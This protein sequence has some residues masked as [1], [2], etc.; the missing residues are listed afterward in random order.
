MKCGGKGTLFKMQHRR[1]DGRKLEKLLWSLC[2]GLN[3]S[4]HL[5]LPKL[6]SLLTFCNEHYLKPNMSKYQRFN[7]ASKMLLGS[8]QLVL[9]FL[10]WEKGNR[11]R[12]FS[13]EQKVKYG[14]SLS[15]VGRTMRGG[16]C[17]EHH[18]VRHELW[19]IKCPHFLVEFC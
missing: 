16:V 15:C 19:D 5:R 18:D 13:T 6:I 1:Y 10:K 2:T 8:T 11:R 7:C 3:C 14:N 12:Q 9:F 4:F 17:A